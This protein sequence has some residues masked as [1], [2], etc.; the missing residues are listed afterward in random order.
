MSARATIGRSASGSGYMRPTGRSSDDKRLNQQQTDITSIEEARGTDAAR[1]AEAMEAD[2]NQV[3]ELQANQEALPRDL[4]SGNGVRHGVRFMGSRDRGQ[5]G[6][7][8]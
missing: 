2:R 7:A 3:A 1:L 8:C 6:S 4:K 5:H